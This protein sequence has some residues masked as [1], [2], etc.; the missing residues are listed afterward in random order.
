MLTGLPSQPGCTDEF[1]WDKPLLPAYLLQELQLFSFAPY[2]LQTSHLPAASSP[3]GSPGIWPEPPSQLSTKGEPSGLSFP[4]SP[5]I[6]SLPLVHIPISKPINTSWAMDCIQTKPESLLW[7]LCQM[8]SLG[9][10]V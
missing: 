10:K 9:A 4:P 3:G 5:I 2:S 7:G 1:A 8:V 6:D